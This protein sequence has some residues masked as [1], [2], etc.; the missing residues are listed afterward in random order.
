MLAA[1]IYV[2]GLVE[3][4]AC[5]HTYQAISNVSALWKCR[6]D[7]GDDPHRNCWIARLPPARGGGR[8]APGLEPATS[9][10]AADAPSTGPMGLVTLCWGTGVPCGAG[11]EHER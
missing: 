6:V 9:G 5:V 8:A 11:T 4:G 2:G 3:L 10:T 1:A 7:G